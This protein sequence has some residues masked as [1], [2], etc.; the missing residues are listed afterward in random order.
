MSRSSEIDAE[1][2]QDFETNPWL[3]L[4]KV[5]CLLNSRAT[6]D[7]DRTLWT[8]L[9]AVLSLTRGER[10]LLLLLDEHGNPDV[11]MHRSPGGGDPRKDQL[12]RTVVQQVFESGKGLFVPEIS[13]VP[14]LA[15]AQ[16]VSDLAIRS[17]LCV[18]LKT[19]L[20]EGAASDAER[21]RYP[22][23]LVLWQEVIGAIYV[24]SSQ[25]RAPYTEQDLVLL[26]ALANIAATAITN[27]RLHREATRDPDTGLLTRRYFELILGKVH[28]LSRRFD[29]PYGLL[30]IDL[31]PAAPG[32]VALIGR[33]L[34]AL[35]RESDLPA[36][37]GSH[38][39][40]I[41]LPYAGIEQVHLV[42]Q[43]I[44]SLL[45]GVR[46]GASAAP[47][48]ATGDIELSL[49][50]DHA[51]AT[52][53]ANDPFV[54]WSPDI[55]TSGPRA[56][57]LAGLITSNEGADHRSLERLVRENERLRQSLKGK[58]TFLGESPALLRA[59][60]RVRKAAPTQVSVL[61]R[62]ESGSGKELIAQALHAASPRAEK[63]FV[64]I[65]CGAIPD[66]L[67][68]S[69]LFGHEAGAFTGATR[70]HRGKFEQADGGT[71]FLD[72]IGELTL[73]LQARFLR[74]LQEHEL[75]RLG[76]DE[77]IRV[78]VRIVAATH[79]DLEAEIAAGSFRQDLFYRLNQLQIELPPLRER[80]RDVLTLAHF[81]LDQFCLQLGRQP[82]K[83][84]SDATEA[85]L[86][87]TWP[88]NVRELEH[89]V[90]QA[91]ILADSEWITR[92]DLRLP[93]KASSPAPESFKKA[94]RRAIDDF[95]REYIM[96]MLE[97]HAGDIDQC[98]K[99]MGLSQRRFRE[100]RQKLSIR[101]VRS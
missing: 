78:D 66:N 14:E 71:L 96:R 54:F 22:P 50:A 89:C 24:D 34:S 3:A 31:D 90:Q 77:T 64:V 49:Q 100:L 84:H 41:L 12:S 57:R 98:A 53:T 69:E 13:V 18:P 8:I 97:R 82:P 63:P 93:G 87:H 79:R 38:A 5:S 10:A 39:F 65:D 61:V 59:L 48:P 19:G 40:A 44:Q 21:R 20:F 75:Q 88:G 67:V 6:V 99:S 47:D 26:E 11:Q 17:A 29:F 1:L 68:E 58:V 30:R 51:L 42:A 28:R 37:Y 55:G 81:F 80:G 101:S 15:S 16:S 56:D 60:D 83:L 4:Y 32:D 52:T 74:V 7:L 86:D 92:D 76:A 46:I 73:A 95:E 2:A 45:G 33:T 72:E 9:S 43:K 85:L 70:R 27:A 35:L 36:R 94:R 23:Y 62:G 25:A 91:A